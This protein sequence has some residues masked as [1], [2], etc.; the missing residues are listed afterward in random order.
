MKTKEI[1]L[2]SRDGITRI[3][4]RVDA[5]QICPAL[6]RG[7]SDRIARTFGCECPGARIWTGDGSYHE[8]EVVRDED[9]DAR[10]DY[11]GFY[12]DTREGNVQK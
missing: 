12:V 1:E 4:I 9:W 11:A 2:Y 6:S 8:L 3:M 5:G 7:Q 10:G